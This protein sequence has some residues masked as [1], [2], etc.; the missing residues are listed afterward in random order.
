MA[1]KEFKVYECDLKGKF[2]YNG[3]TYSYLV[4][5]DRD[6]IFDA[7]RVG[8]AE[9]RTKEYL[10]GELDAFH[11]IGEYLDRINACPEDLE[12]INTVDSIQKALNIVKTRMILN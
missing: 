8:F 5:R 11:S 6:V 7:L 2:N 3:F 1:N 4:V 9:S 12:L 10:G